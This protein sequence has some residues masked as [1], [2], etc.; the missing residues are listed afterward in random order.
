MEHI[1][2]QWGT[3][4]LFKKPKDSLQGRKNNEQINKEKINPSIAESDKRCR[5]ERGRQQTRTMSV[6][7]T[8][9]VPSTPGEEATARHNL[10]PSPSRLLGVSVTW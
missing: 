1:K 6:S 4:S 2:G 3:R 7:E 10:C 5:K 8:S 9:C